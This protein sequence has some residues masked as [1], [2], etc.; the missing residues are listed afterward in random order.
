MYWIQTSVRLPALATKISRYLSHS[1]KIKARIITENITWPLP[2][3]FIRH[4][5]TDA[6]E[7]RY[8]DKQKIQTSLEPEDFNTANIKVCHWT[9]S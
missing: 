8:Q 6:A 5:I 1:L 2:S 4:Y 3:T 9:R 7:R